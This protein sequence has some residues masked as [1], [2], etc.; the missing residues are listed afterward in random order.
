M[1]GN[2]KEFV[3]DKIEK[4]ERKWSIKIDYSNIKVQFILRLELNQM[5]RNRIFTI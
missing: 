4:S 2:K 5:K 1:V 3:D